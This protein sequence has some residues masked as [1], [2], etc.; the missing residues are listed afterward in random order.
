M[1]K[2]KKID[3]FTLELGNDLCKEEYLDNILK[4]VALIRKEIF[5]KY[6]VVL[7]CVRVKNNKGL[8]PLEYVIKVENFQTGNF[9][10]KKN[11]IM[12]IDTS[13]VETDPSHKST[14]LTHE[15]NTPDSRIKGERTLEPVFGCPALWIPKSQKELASANGYLTLS[16]EK[17]I[18]IHL[19]EIVK[20]NLSSVITTKYVSNLMDE[21]MKDNS[22]LCSL[23]ILNA[24]QC[25]TV[26]KKVLASLLEE[27]VSIRNIESI[28]ETIAD[29]EKVTLKNIQQLINKVRNSIALEIIY[30]LLEKNVLNVFLISQELTE[31]LYD[32][33]VLDDVHD[34]FVIE[35]EIKEWFYCEIFKAFNKS[36][37]SGDLRIICCSRF[38]RFELY[39]FLK[40]AI[41]NICVISVE[42][43]TSA[44]RKFNFSFQVLDIIGEN[45]VAPTENPPHEAKTRKTEEMEEMEEK[46]TFLETLES[47]ISDY[48]QNGLADTSLI[49]KN[50]ALSKQLFSKIRSSKKDYHP[51]K[52]TVFQL[53]VGL[54]LDLA[55]TERLLAS[56][57]YFFE[58]KN[59]VDR[60]V[61]SH[62]KNLDFD[63]HAIN[64]E[65]WKETGTPFLK[66]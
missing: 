51:H 10:F 57:G 33:I 27:K 37:E 60:I 4:S 24:P 22:T 13:D 40:N 36:K 9:E 32:H 30:P 25:T 11:S 62:I 43:L 23:I 49:W 8:K 18:K 61:K 66:E 34:D 16:T 19:S 63:I 17:I 54:H 28:L 45:F 65:V 47:Y 64:S 1:E 59:P 58:E 3:L 2:Y 7:P 56:A 20:K 42:E 44:Y 14:T 39:R 41:K 26:V 31:Y 29:E 12:I 52:E 15:I 5:I 21:V 35:H 6:G 46:R 48:S 53:A 38:I 50:G 55:Q